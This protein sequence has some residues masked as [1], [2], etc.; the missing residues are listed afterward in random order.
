MPEP[1]RNRFAD[2]KPGRSPRLSPHVSLLMIAAGVRV[3][4]ESGALAGETSADPLLVQR[5]LEFVPGFR[6]ALD[7][8]V[9]VARHAGCFAV[10]ASRIATMGSA[11]LGND[12]GR[13]QERGGKQSRDCSYSWRHA[14]LGLSATPWAATHHT[15]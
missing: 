9:G 5:L 3:L 1:N 8:A 6:A 4:R 14:S 13:V 15:R 2:V 11:T 7:L 12:H 10:C